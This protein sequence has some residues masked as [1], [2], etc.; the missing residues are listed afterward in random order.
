VT[1]PNQFNIVFTNNFADSASSNWAY[2]RLQLDMVAC[3]AKDTQQLLS[4]PQIIN[5]NDSFTTNERTTK[6]TQPQLELNLMQSLQNTTTKN[7]SILSMSRQI[8][9]KFP[10]WLD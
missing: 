6:A 10:Q 3:T 2:T 1:I 4:V 5:K 9:N 7:S 8:I